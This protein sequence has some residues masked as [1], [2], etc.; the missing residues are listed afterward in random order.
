MAEGDWVGV[1]GSG[2][3]LLFEECEMPLIISRGPLIGAFRRLH[4]RGHQMPAVTASRTDRARDFILP[5]RCG[6]RWRRFGPQG[7]QRTMAARLLRAPARLRAVATAR[8]DRHRR[9]N[10]NMQK[11]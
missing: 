9:N 4:M 6:Y 1:S 11:P 2:R 3:R 8:C 5:L 10:Q 7:R